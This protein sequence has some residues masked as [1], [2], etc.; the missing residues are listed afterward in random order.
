M[1][2]EQQEE[3]QD[4]GVNRRSFIR[5]LSLAALAAGAAGTGAAL[6]AGTDLRLQVRRAAGGV[7]GHIHVPDVRAER[8]GRGP[9]EHQDV[10]LDRGLRVPRTRS[11]IPAPR[12][13]GLGSHAPTAPRAPGR[14]GDRALRLPRR[15]R[16]HP[17]DSLFTT[18]V[19]NT[20]NGLAILVERFTTTWTPAVQIG[21][22]LDIGTF[23]QRLRIPDLFF[24]AS[25]FIGI[26][27][28]HHYLHDG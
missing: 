23:H 9:P 24:P 20:E 14:L 15:E 5:N 18:L 10:E 2:E 12:R 11:R 28:F 25:R 22:A 21:I 13:A 7:R 17:T 3:H 16:G 27:I 4:E 6:A 8:H 19:F 26:S 1:R